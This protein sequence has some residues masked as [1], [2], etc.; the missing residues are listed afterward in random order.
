M[1]KRPGPALL[2]A[3]AAMLLY[4]STLLLMQV[5]VVD[6]A[7]IFLRYARNIREGAGPVFNPGEAVE[8]YTSPLWLAVLTALWPLPVARESLA[9]GA[10]IA[11]GAVLLIVLLWRESRG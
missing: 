5:G 4:A 10:S 11:C 8:G 7:Y 2:C 6:D 3:S 9:S 1:L